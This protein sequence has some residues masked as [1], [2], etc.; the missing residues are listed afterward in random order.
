MCR[1]FLREFAADLPILAVNLAG[2]RR[3]YRLD[4]L[5]PHAFVLPAESERR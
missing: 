2:N 3:E 5:L 1:E 4:E